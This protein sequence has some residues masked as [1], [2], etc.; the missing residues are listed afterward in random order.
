M[1]NQR[2]S[3]EAISALIIITVISGC[4]PED[5]LEWSEDGSVGLLSIDKA[6][7][8]VDGQT[9]ELTEIEKENV[10]PWPDISK[11]GS[12]IV[13]IQEIECLNLSEGLKLLP[14]GQVKMIKFYADQVKKMILSTGK[15]DNNKFPFPNEGPLVPHDY[16]NW[17]IRYICE[18]SDTDLLQKLGDE[19]ARKGKEEKIVYFQII[20]VPRDALDKKRIIA[21]NLFAAMASQLSPNGKFVAYL[22]HNQQGQVDNAF[23]EY[24]LYVA[25]L[26]GVVKAMLVD[27]PVAIGYSW[28]DDSRAIAYL[29][30]DSE[31]LI[32][33][34]P[35]M[36]TLKERF[37]VDENDSLLSEPVSIL[38]GTAGTHWCTG[39]SKQ[40]AGT[41]F[42]PWMKVDYALSCRVFFSS[43]VASIPSS[44][45]D[46][47]K[48][49][50]FSYD[51][52]TGAVTN[53]LPSSISDY[54][55]GNVNL[56]AI[57][58]DGR[59]VILPMRKNRFAIYELGK[60]S[61]NVPINEN[62][63]FGEENVLE[64]APAWKGNNEISCLVSEKSHF[65]IKEG[66]EKYH[67]KEIVILG[68]DGKFLRVL[69]NNW[70]GKIV[71]TTTEKGSSG[72]P[73]G[74]LLK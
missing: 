18:T 14:Q 68:A 71:G 43:P 16:R 39:K 65:L 45:L 12:L 34:D 40:M 13:Y 61:A 64:F 31:N 37:I 28:R 27:H 55:E 23:E 47:E 7:Y 44:N 73:I 69:S 53:V 54:V 66:Q 29:E 48:W 36:A 19:S 10:L 50:L 70:P 33:S 60:S 1:N 72:V 20:I 2:V 5:S 9:G 6:L 3:W 22:M 17:V 4:I 41:M 51:S 8:I 52:V 32:H 30:A 11:D 38:Q 63:I 49:S 57:S 67:R 26:D 46:E 25:S 42:N 74:Q 56:F 58:P 59:K 21:T 24:G 35:I 15:P 62:E